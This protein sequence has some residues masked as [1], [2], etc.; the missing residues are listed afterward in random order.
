MFEVVLE[1]KYREVS[2]A[3]HGARVEV[4]PRQR[5]RLVDPKKS[6]ASP[7]LH[8]CH[9]MLRKRGTHNWK[10]RWLLSDFIFNY[11]LNSHTELYFILLI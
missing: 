2:G 6:W 9:V 4:D 8:L 11:T 10:G 5:H 1:R 3:D 7:T